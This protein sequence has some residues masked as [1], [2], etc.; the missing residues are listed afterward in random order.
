MCK[1]TCSSLTGVEL[2]FQIFSPL[3]MI[4]MQ[5]LKYQAETG[6]SSHAN[7]TEIAGTAMSESWSLIYNVAQ[8]VLTHK[9]IKGIAPTL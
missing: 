7:T 9:D 5:K 1:Q 3:T 4:I 2:C 8:I 6:I